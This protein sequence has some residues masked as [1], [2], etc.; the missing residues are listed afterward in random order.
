M[1]FPMS[2][3]S[4]IVC[5]TCQICI[6]GHSVF[7]GYL[8]NEERTGEALDADGWLHT[9]DVGQWLP[10]RSLQLLH[11]TL[12]HYGLFVCSVY[13]SFKELIH[14]KMEILFPQVVPVYEILSS[15]EHKIR[16]LE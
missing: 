8:K 5:Y 12:S 9:G 4:L 7:R 16:Y 10:V 3:N 11:I 14:P 2:F 13:L 15:V 6:R 1:D